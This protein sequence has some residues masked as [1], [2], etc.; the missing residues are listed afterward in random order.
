MRG[1]ILAAGLGERLRPLTSV[2][3]KPAIEFL[4]VPMLTFPYHWLNSLGLKELTFNTHHLP[5]T[6]RHAAMHVVDPAIPMH[7]THED[8]ILGSGGGIWNARFHLQDRESFVVANG[9]GVILCEDDDVLI[10]MRE[11]HE[12]QKALA[13]L[14]VC[15]LEGVGERIPG[16]WMDP[17][18]EVGGFGKVSPGPRFQCFHYASYIFLSPRVW[19][20]LPA[21]SSNI[22]YDV[23]LP[24]IALGEKVFGFRI[25]NMK[26]FETGNVA[27]Y[28]SAT[29]TCLEE[30]RGRTRLGKCAH[31]LLE[32]YGPPS[33]Q[34]SD[35]SMLRLQAD[36]AEVAPSA[37]LKGLIVLGADGRVGPFAKLEDCV[38]LPGTQVAADEVHKAEILIS[39]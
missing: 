11:F 1:L 21:G 7:F 32:K 25:D 28:L 20:M 5:E 22:L 2:R 10:R 30:M 37:A 29:R 27:D 17:F 35:L 6:I 33:S 12:R 15:P 14:L 34:R 39:S 31:D 9:D 23:L 38:V 4:N 13:T 24:Q 16:V 18:G 19:E 26:W 8:M 36:T 3:A